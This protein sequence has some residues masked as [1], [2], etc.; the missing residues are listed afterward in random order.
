MVAPLA[1]ATPDMAATYPIQMLAHQI[2][3]HQLAH[4]LATAKAPCRVAE[5]GDLMAAISG[6]NSQ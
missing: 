4:I 5:T 6:G 3:V 1:Q 2:E